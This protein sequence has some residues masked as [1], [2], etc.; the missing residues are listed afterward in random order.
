M[1]CRRVHQ[2]HAKKHYVTGNAARLS[3]VDL[4]R[5][6]LA[7]LAQLDIEE[8][9]D[10]LEILRPSRMQYVLDIMRSHMD[11][12][13]EQNRVS[14]LSMEPLRLVQWQESHLR[15]DKS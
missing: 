5:R 15:S 14:D 9:A 13:I 10:M 4:D 1:V 3:V 12:G 2:Q 11:D 6:L 7:D 8:T